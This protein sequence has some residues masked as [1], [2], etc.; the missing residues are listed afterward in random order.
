LLEISRFHTPEIAVAHEEANYHERLKIEQ[1]SSSNHYAKANLDVQFIM[2]M[3]VAEEAETT[4][5]NIDALDLL[6]WIRSQ[7]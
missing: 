4:F 6:W 5:L 3:A 1:L 7:R 2:N